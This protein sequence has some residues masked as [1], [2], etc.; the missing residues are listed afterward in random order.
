MYSKC[1]FS[2]TTLLWNASQHVDVY[3]TLCVN[4]KIG[5][6]QLAGS[7]GLLLNSKKNIGDFLSYTYHFASDNNYL[8]T[9]DIWI[10]VVFFLWF[11]KHQRSVL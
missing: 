4:T 9:G 2:L 11:L 8:S 5:M 7:N 3:I 1:H 10:T 6:W